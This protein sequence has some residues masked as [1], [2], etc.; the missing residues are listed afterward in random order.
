MMNEKLN[1]IRKHIDDIDD[2][3]LGL[4]NQRIA[5]IKEVG[6]LK[7]QQNAIIYRP[8]REKSI[9]ERL[10]Q[11]N[12][13][14]L[15]REAIESIFLEIF[16]VSRNFELPE[17][18]A[19]LGPEGT[20]SHQAA[21][22]RFGSMSS[23]VALG[24]IQSVFESVATGRV[25]FGVVPIENNQEGTV[26]ET[27]DLLAS[28]DVKIAAEIPMNIHFTF[29]SEEDRLENIKTIYSKDIAFKQCSKFLKD[30]FGDKKVEFVP[31]ES[32]SKAALLAKQNKQAAALCSH[33]A[34][35]INDLPLLFENIEDS[36]FN[37]TR[38]LILSKNFVNQSSQ[39]DKTTFIAKITDQAGSLADLLD[40]FRA[41][42][43]NLTKIESR[44][45]KHLA[46]FKYWFLI[47]FDGHFADKNVQPIMEK[48]QD[49]LKFM[50]SYVKLC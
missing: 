35:K 42:K 4:L 19:Y 22:S 7:R 26:V 28:T 20:F 29:A 47:E 2:Q 13:G 43:I 1:Q 8:E 17:R 41:A 25:R 12:D 10:E 27:I 3:L 40:E 18:V 9:L 33:I 37:R 45:I 5:L 31:V 15:T 44:P 6:E 14:A 23:Y 46:A 34:A 16:A 36:A 38:F 48:Y 50:G 49:V 39:N 21:E 24:S 11:R 32:T 30:Y